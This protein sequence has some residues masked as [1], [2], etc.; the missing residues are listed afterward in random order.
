MV[1]LNLTSLGLVLLIIISNLI[2]VLGLLSGNRL[3]IYMTVAGLTHGL[4]P[5]VI[6]TKDSTRLYPD[7]IT[8]TINGF[9][10]VVLGTRFTHQVR[11]RLALG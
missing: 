1:A 5:L 2:N 8:R 7:T 4:Q 9:I 3:S 6:R 10:V 11:A